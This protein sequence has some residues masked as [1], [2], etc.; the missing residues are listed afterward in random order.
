[1]KL[2][3]LFVAFSLAA[4]AGVPMAVPTRDEQ[5]KAFAPGP[6]E[7]AIYLFRDQSVAANVLVPVSIDGRVAGKTAEQTYFLWVVPPGE[8]RLVS[9]DSEPDALTLRTEPGRVYFVRH[10]ITL[11]L[12]EP[13]FALRQVDEERGR[14]G[15]R[16]S[17]RAIDLFA[18]Q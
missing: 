12:F 2:A 18:P 11:K 14:R 1:M 16:I 17:W 13:S 15:L 4:C 7:S 9:H 10:E 5:G 6:D 3:P 8:H